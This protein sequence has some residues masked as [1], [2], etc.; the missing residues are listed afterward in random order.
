M[1]EFLLLLFENPAISNFLFLILKI[2]KQIFICFIS[3]FFC[4]SLFAN[5]FETQIQPENLN[6]T[7]QTNHKCLEYLNNVL[8]DKKNEEGIYQYCK[9]TFDNIRFCCT[10]PS[11]CQESW[12]RDFAQNL[13]KNSLN[14]VKNLGGDLLSCELNRLSGLT[15]SLSGIQNEI[16]NLGIK[17]CAVDC[18]NKLRE[19]TKTFRQ[20]FSVPDSY[21]IEEF[22][23]KAK[24]TVKDQVCYKKMRETV[25]KYKEQSLNKKASLREELKATDIIK[26]EDIQKAK[27]SQ[28]LNRFVLNMCYR[29]QT[30]KQEQDKKEAEQKEKKETREAQVRQKTPLE[31]DKSPSLSHSEQNKTKPEIQNVEPYS[32]QE[33]PEEKSHGEKYPLGTKASLSKGTA[34]SLPENRYEKNPDKKTEHSSFNN[35]EFPYSS[36]KQK[37]K[38]TEFSQ[39]FFGKILNV[40]RAPIKE[41]SA[42]VRGWP[43]SRFKKVIKKLK[44]NKN[45]YPQITHQL[46][47]QSV[48][49]PQVEYLTEQELQNHPETPVFKSY[50]LVKGKPAGVLIQIQLPRH[51]FQ[52]VNIY[53]CVKQSDFN[54]Q[55]S[56]K[57]QPVETK[58][59]PLIKTIKEGWQFAHSSESSNKAC[60]FSTQDFSSTDPVIYKFIELDTNK[61]DPVELD[62]Y[63]K[64]ESVSDLEYGSFNHPNKIIKE[65]HTENSHVPVRVNIVEQDNIIQNELSI[66][67]DDENKLSLGNCRDNIKLHAPNEFC[68]NVLELE[69]LKLAFT[70]IVGGVYNNE[71][72]DRCHLPGL[73]SKDL[74][75][76]NGYSTVSPRKVMNFVKSIEVENFLPTILPLTQ[77]SASV[78][79]TKEEK[80]DFILGNCDNSM[81]TRESFELLARRGFHRGSQHNPFSSTKLSFGLLKDIINLKIE[82][83]KWKNK[84]G[85]YTYNKLFAVVSKNYFLYHKLHESLGAPDGSKIY[86]FSLIPEYHEAAGGNLH[87][88]NDPWNFLGDVAFIRE[89]QLN[90]GTLSHELAH[91]LGQRKDFYEESGKCSRFREDP[92]KSENCREYKIPKALNTKIKNGKLSWQFVT[93]K[94]SIM[95]RKLDLGMLWIDRES[96]Q[97]IFAII[98]KVSTVIKEKQK[99]RNSISK[100]IFISGFYRK[101][102]NSFVVPKIKILETSS[103]TSFDS[104]KPVLGDRDHI[105]FQLKD[106]KDNVLQEIIQPVLKTRLEVLY[107]K[108]NSR[109]V[110]CKTFPFDFFYIDAFFDIP[111]NRKLED[112][113]I[114]VLGPQGSEIFTAFV[115][116]EK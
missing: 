95:G 34:I 72:I 74:S 107:Q 108:E 112:L 84:D 89:D 22:L 41:A 92:L 58:C 78:L 3:L 13:R 10:D 77:L 106:K 1:K 21:S 83:A 85:K 53:E 35:N 67:V 30:Q 47:Y 76:P 37:E 56:V 73:K 60:A 110:D 93:D 55:L 62:Q 64:I 69:G 102:R 26:C 7:C 25:K 75:T 29:A 61:I 88:L 100:K 5:S 99:Q 46:V 20:C 24:K 4:S 52:K 40:I 18:E 66:K 54:L 82:K 94:F 9:I 90:N 27:S 38:T 81:V 87:I 80:Q 68:L 23:E 98:A 6:S 91:L 79:I 96:Y 114:V 15:N 70:R 19:V 33:N 28:S 115:P 8:L 2:K 101:K 57:N 49:A 32:N 109:E 50:D 116:K 71:K 111:E 65:I 105:T 36:Q 31:G 97:R 11:Q 86:G 51:C 44:T 12:G 14:K 104:K 16:C 113:R 63:I 48:E 17:N 59:V 45:G 39:T 42:R 103:N 43:F